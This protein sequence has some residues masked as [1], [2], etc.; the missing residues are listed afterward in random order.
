[1][2]RYFFCIGLLF[3]LFGSIK[4][5][6]NIDNNQQN[7]FT[8]A[9]LDS[10]DKLH[11]HYVYLYSDKMIIGSTLNL[12]E[13]DLYT[14]YIQIDSLKYSYE[15]VKFYKDNNTLYANVKDIAPIHNGKFA[16]K[17][18]YG[19]INLFKLSYNS[20]YYG[21]SVKAARYYYCFGFADL[22]KVKYG[23]LKHIVSD[24]LNFNRYM[25]KAKS[26]R[27][28]Q[29]I[30]YTSGSALLA[31]GLILNQ[32]NPSDNPNTFHSMLIGAGMVNIV[33]GG[34]FSISKDKKLR[35]AIL[36]HD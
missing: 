8:K 13:H 4:S 24:D 35:K 11:R 34:V 1:M 31:S 14:Q 9:L 36:Y 3:I 16:Q 20:F 26:A 19:S 33:I 28:L 18:S 10:L 15:Q 27:T 6:V 32:N 21:N 12:N 7:N 2:K 25:G 29:F 5:Q 22:K 30:L 17:I 23:N